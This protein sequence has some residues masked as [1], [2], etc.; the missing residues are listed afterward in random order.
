[1]YISVQRQA[2]PLRAHQAVR[3]DGRTRSS[4]RPAGRCN[5]YESFDFNEYALRTS[6]D[7]LMPPTRVGNE[8]LALS[9]EPKFGVTQKL[10]AL[11]G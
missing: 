5:P 8:L 2:T 10:W 3:A 4:I 6:K 9:A 11:Q 7:R 1:V